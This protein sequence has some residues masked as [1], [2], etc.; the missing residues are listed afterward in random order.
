V[1]LQAGLID[2]HKDSKVLSRADISSQATIA[3]TLLYARELEKI[4]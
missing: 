2:F 4:V 3:N 1:N